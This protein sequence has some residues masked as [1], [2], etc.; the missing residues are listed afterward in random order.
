MLLHPRGHRQDIGI[1]DDIL[2]R[3]ADVVG[4]N[5]IGAGADL[6]LALHG[7]CLA[8][9]VKRHYHRRSAVPLQQFRD[10]PKRL[11]ALLQADRV[12][13]RFPLHTF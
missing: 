3:K 11:L 1:E 5:M 4:Q 6:D 7:V 2:W 9:F 12:D 8:R 10:L 13:D